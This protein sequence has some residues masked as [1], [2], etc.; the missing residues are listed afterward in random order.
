MTDTSQDFK[1]RDAASYDSLTAEFDL[2]TQKFARLF[3]ERLVG[4]A[5][6]EP[7]DCV[8]DVGTG[9]GVVALL[10]AQK[11]TGSG[12]V[13]GVDL[14]DQMLASAKS[15][16]AK[17]GFAD[18][19]KFCR[20][21]AEALTLKDSSF[22]T[23]LSLFAILHFPNPLAALREIYR[24]LRPGGRLVLAF[25]S[26]PRLVSW[27]GVREGLRYLRRRS[28]SR[29][30]TLLVGPRCL[31]DFVVQRIAE[32]EGPEESELARDSR[33]RAKSVPRLFREAGFT[34]VQ[35]QWFG[36]EAVIDT[37]EEFWEIQRTFSSIA[38]KRLLGLPSE[39][40]ETLRSEFLV[41]CRSVQ[42]RG[43][44]LIYPI[45][46]LYVIARRPSA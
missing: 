14:S 25:G 33:N 15:K 39:R 1:F 18:R 28:A 7:N 26:G 27:A 23:S 21:D 4:I 2:F 13:L 43:G 35:T 38:R 8:L 19:V 12:T 45:A 46:A 29:A 6:L 31:D 11:L 32:H 30:G 20:M 3:A 36:T 44:K 24:V 41:S 40:L 5:A 37:P 10:A 17:R 34:E 16:A 42:S 9:T 22:D